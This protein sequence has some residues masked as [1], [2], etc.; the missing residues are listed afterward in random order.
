MA[1]PRRFL[2]ASLF[3]SMLFA[4]VPALA[5]DWPSSVTR[6]VDRLAQQ[7]SEPER[8]SMESLFQNAL[9]LQEQAMHIE[10]GEAWLETLSERQFNT[11]RRLLRGMRLS[12]GYDVFVAPDPDFFQHL[13]LEKGL[14][15]DREFFR[16]YRQSWG[17]DLFPTYLRQTS[18]VTP[19]V[20]FSE[21]VIPALY[22]AWIDYRTAFPQSYSTYVEQSIQDLEEIVT[23]GTC[24][25]ED[26]D[27]VEHAL[28]GF[29]RLFPD[30]PAIPGIVTRLQ[31]LEDEPSTIPVHCR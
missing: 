15:A 9:A 22:V 1:R 2:S 4:S 17:D 21:G 13:S 20:R 27:S 5:D 18:R 8:Q 11:L 31:Q 7:E 14:D 23:L 28:S 30:S 24:A 29:V 19:C 10:D 6:Y 12:R 3:A 16:R 26:Q 25:C